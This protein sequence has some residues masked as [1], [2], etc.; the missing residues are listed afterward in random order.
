[1]SN[2]TVS[3]QIADL[4]RQAISFANIEVIPAEIRN[5]LENDWK[6]PKA[7]DFFI[8]NSEICRILFKNP[9]DF[10]MLEIIYFGKSVRGKTNGVDNFFYESLSGQALRDRLR[11]V[12][13]MTANWLLNKQNI[14]VI[15]FGAGPAPYAIETVKK[16]QGQVNN[17]LWRCLDL[18]RLAIA[19]G[20]DRVREHKLD[21]VI[22]FDVANFMSRDFYPESPN[23]Q[24]DFGLMIGI[25]CGMTCEEA[26]NCL[27]KVQPHFK[28]GGEI[29]AATLL[30][31][32][33]EEDPQNF[34]ILC[35]VLDWQLRP[36]TIPEVRGV[37]E[38]A[39]WKILNVSSERADGNGQYA[40]VHAQ[41]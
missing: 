13:D 6:N 5:L 1:M 25:L 17:L 3:E 24:A 31:Q 9:A 35:N 37:F 22:T 4:G 14:R 10:E 18:D 32:S 41:L 30:K 16:L 21:N 27:Q 34:R 36:K 2:K 15:D 7:L 23:E 28:K 39:G 26:T 33:F 40:I 12:S 8:N 20:R 38:N 19:I 29:I 11:V